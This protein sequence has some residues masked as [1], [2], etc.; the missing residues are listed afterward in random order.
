MKKRKIAVFIAIFIIVAL[1]VVVVNSQRQGKLPD[2]KTVT[3]TKGD[4]Q[5]LLSTNALIQSKETKS[6]LGQA[7]LKVESVNFEVG[8][9]VKKG[10]VLLTYDIDD[11]VLS[12]KQAR[13]Q[14]D[15]A[16]LNREELLN[17]KDEIEKDIIELDEQIFALDGSSNPQDIATLQQLIQKRKSIQE[18]SKEKIQLMDNS[19]ALAELSLTSAQDRLNEAE[20][21]LK[22]A[23]DGVVTVVNAIE[24][25]PLSMSQPAFVVQQLDNLKGVVK[26]GKYDAAKIRIGQKVTLSNG[27]RTYE[28]IVS[29]VDPAA[30]KE[31]GMGTDATLQAEIDILNPDDLLKVDFDINA[32]ILIGEARNV[33]TLP[34]ECIQFNRDDTSVFVVKDG[35]ARSTIVKI[36]LQSDTSVEIVEGLSEGDVV[37]SNPSIEIQDGTVVTKEGMKR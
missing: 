22:S 32:D 37:I 1:A 31:P 30:K 7:Q 28:G 33:L 26:L 4:I 29:F 21:G 3:V 9:K 11:L 12:V 6:Y 8:Q 17:Q 13:I 5:T 10:D 27:E 35:I 14:Y 16:L 19:V 18:V 20:E 34:I 2:I 24:G 15:N 36:G 23:I 25:S